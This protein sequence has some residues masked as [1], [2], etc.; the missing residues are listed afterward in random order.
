MLYRWHV[1]DAI[2][3]DRNWLPKFLVTNKKKL[4]ETRQDLMTFCNKIRCATYTKFV[5]T[6]RTTWP[7]L[8]PVWTITHFKRSGV[9]N[10][11]FSW[12]PSSCPL[13]VAQLLERVSVGVISDTVDHETPRRR[14]TTAQGKNVV[15]TAL[16]LWLAH[17]I[18]TL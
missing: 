6:H 5:L 11:F 18:E 13:R 10:H 16:K 9:Y 15:L 14:T 17:L 4:N 1:S 7:S 12:L 8:S 3:L 2:S